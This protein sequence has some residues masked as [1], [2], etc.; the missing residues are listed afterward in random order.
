MNSDSAIFLGTAGWS[1]PREHWAAFASEG[2]QLQRYAGRFAAVEIDSSFYRPHRP[3]TYAKWAESVPAAFRFC[4]KVPKQ[5]T[6]E[7][8][9]I[10]CD[11]LLARFLS[12][13]GELGEK[14]GCLLLQL[15]PSLALDP[16]S[17]ARFVDVLRARHEGPVVI[18][19]R[20]RSWLDAET[21]LQ[22]ARIARVAA[23]PAPFAE[24][25][26]PGG[27]TGFRYY[28]LHGSPRIYYSAYGDDRLASLTERLVEAPK[29]VDTW[30]IFDN[31][32][33]GAAV[34]DAL[35]MQRLLS[36]H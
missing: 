19:P 20:H 36:A 25:A 2:S 27:W 34:A 23:D 18:E 5:I 29:G 1:L 26:R 10:D 17:A 28:R 9:L 24:A 22:Q 11:E 6:H 30:C 13:C 15:P 12:E 3:A 14:L 35:H 31:T 21:L 8:R 33:S 4:V 16:A 32:A 7:R